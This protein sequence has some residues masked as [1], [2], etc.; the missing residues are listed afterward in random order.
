MSRKAKIFV[1]RAFECEISVTSDEDFTFA[2]TQFFETIRPDYL[3]S[4][5]SLGHS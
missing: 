3:D 1:T 4:G 2:G 5:G